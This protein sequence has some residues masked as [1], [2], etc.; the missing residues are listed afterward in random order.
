M[1]LLFV[2]LGVAAY[3]VLRRGAVAGLGSLAMVVG[4][5]LLV[6]AYAISILE[7]TALASAATDLGANGAEAL[8]VAEEAGGVI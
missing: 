3:R 5:V 2:P 4:L 7:A 6:P 8:Y 1:S